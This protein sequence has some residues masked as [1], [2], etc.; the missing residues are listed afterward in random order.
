[1][2]ISV[3]LERLD[4][5]A[6]SSCSVLPSKQAYTNI[7]SGWVGGKKLHEA[8]G[9]QSKNGHVLQHVTS[10]PTRGACA[11]HDVPAH[12]AGL[13]LLPR[14]IVALPFLNIPDTQ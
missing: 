14:H 1:M 2:F 13:C 11:P 4:S 5:L 6:Q 8:R 9:D 12:S 3:G 10:P 7:S